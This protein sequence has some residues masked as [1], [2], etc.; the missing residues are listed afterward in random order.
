MLRKL[1]RLSWGDLPVLTEALV[2]VSAIRLAL[3]FIPF[4][5]FTLAPRVAPCQDG[6]TNRLR[7][8]VLAAAAVVPKST[9]LVR[10]LAAQRLFAL[11]GHVSRLHIGVAPSVEEGLAAHAWLE[12]RGDILVGGTT[13]QFSPILA[14]S[15]AI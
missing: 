6:D 11:H 10:A 3:W 14:R 4:R 5:Y 15:A 8:A 13:T 2:L 9:C 1:A 7:W 12:Y